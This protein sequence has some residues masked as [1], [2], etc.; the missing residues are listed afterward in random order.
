MKKEEM[1]K[2]I[3]QIIEFTEDVCIYETENKTMKEVLKYINKQ[4]HT[5]DVLR[6]E[7]EFQIDLRKFWKDNFYQKMEQIQEIVEKSYND[8]DYFNR[9]MRKDIEGLLGE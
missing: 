6:E 7:V 8:I 9:D 5:I 3:K 2:K 1:I 4:N